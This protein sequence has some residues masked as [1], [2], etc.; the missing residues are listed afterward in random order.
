MDVTVSAPGQDV[1]ALRRWLL[2]EDL[3]RGRVSL[4][5][6]TPRP[7]HLGTATDM[8]SVAL[9]SGGAVTALSYALVAWVRQR[10]GDV[11]V[12]V[13]RPDGSGVEVSAERLRGLDAQAVRTLVSEMTTSLSLPSA[14]DP[15]AGDPSSGDPSS[16]GASSGGSEES[17]HGRDSGGR[18]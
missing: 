3:L 4:L 5:D 1:H 6:G 10:S 7:G 18:R 15:S 9:G 11:R 2:D 16:G 8:L 17:E 13:K 12:V 14:G